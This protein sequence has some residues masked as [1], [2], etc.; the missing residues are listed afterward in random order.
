[1]NQILEWRNYPHWSNPIGKHKPLKKFGQTHMQ[2]T[3]N[4]PFHCPYLGA[5]CGFNM[6]FSVTKLQESKREKKKQ[7]LKT[8]KK[9]L[10]STRNKNT[11]HII[12]QN[13]A[14]EK[15]EEKEKKK[16]Q[17]TKQETKIIMAQAHAEK[18]EEDI[19]N[20]QEKEIMKNNNNNNNI[21]SSNNNNSTSSSSASAPFKFNVQAP[22]F[23]PR[24][25]TQ[26]PISGY[27]YPCFQYI[28]GEATGSADWI[29]VGD[30]EPLYVISSPSVAMPS[31]TSKNV[32]TDDLRAKIIKQVSPFR[33]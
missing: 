4:C 14:K 10:K 19:V 13:T 16:E 17:Q 33:N 23:V 12:T 24:S 6:K 21:T 5:K 25:H 32:L 3:V 7:K 15:K 30:Q 26:M 18:I 1:M 8:K 2:A 20:N 9:I 29:F 11:N 27:Y 28:G 31:N 22:E